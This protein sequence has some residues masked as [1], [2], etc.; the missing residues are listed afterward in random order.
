MICVMRCITSWIE[1]LDIPSDSDLADLSTLSLRLSDQLVA[2]AWDEWAQMGMLATPH[3]RSPWAQDPEALFVFTLEVARADAR[4]F[5][6]LMDWMLVN[7]SLLSVRR[8]RAMCIDETDRALT[9]AAL[10]WLARQR[11]RARLS[12]REPTSAAPTLQPL[13]RS[14]G[15]VRAPDEDFAA[16]GWLR[17]PLTPS[18]KSSPPDPTAPINLAFRLRQILG[19]G[20]RAEVV[21]VLLTT[22]VPWINAQTLACSTGYAK[23][24]VHE[25]LAGLSTADVVSAVTVGGEQRYTANRLAWA[26]LLGCQPD[27]LPINRD[28][29]QLLGALR[30]VLRW[31]EQP[32]L[33]TMSDYLRASSTR[34]LLETIRPDLAFAGVPV[35]LGPSPENTLRELRGGHRV[36]AHDHERQSSGGA[37]DG[38]WCL[39]ATSADFQAGPS[40]S[41]STLPPL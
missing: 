30:R 14:G 34:D 12:S 19:V 18:H 13:F 3:R 32:E 39:P 5:D 22:E 11:P 28:W 9:A 40:S 4:L 35:D 15:P 2:F 37:I 31:S 33:E 27:E 16:A 10:G 36:R 21:R 29:P 1:M 20:I 7:E 26:A 17:P 41:G 6:E 23:R 25:A 24:N 8:L 38:R